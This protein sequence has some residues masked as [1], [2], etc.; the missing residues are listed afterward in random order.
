MYVFLTKW[1]QIHKKDIRQ[2]LKNRPPCIW[3]P[4][5]SL[6]PTS[7]PSHTYSA[8]WDRIARSFLLAPV[9]KV[10]NTRFIHVV[11]CFCCFCKG[12][13]YAQLLNMIMKTIKL[14]DK[15]CVH[16]SWL[17]VNY[18]ISQPPTKY[19]RGIICMGIQGWKGCDEGKFKLQGVQE[20]VAKCWT[21]FEK[22]TIFCT[23]TYRES[24]TWAEVKTTCE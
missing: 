15:T 6:R 5:F 16:Y 20:V 1:I 23:Y 7:G 9:V 22:K 3:N 8:A 12:K 4:L 19:W 24:E 21:F 18:N 11:L 14:I 17:Y 10:S 13:I 2:L